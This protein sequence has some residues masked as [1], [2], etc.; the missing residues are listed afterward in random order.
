MLG[1]CFKKN[2]D[3]IKIYSVVVVKGVMQNMFNIILKYNRYIIE[4][5]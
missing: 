3:I 5:E 1:A 4:T 2:K